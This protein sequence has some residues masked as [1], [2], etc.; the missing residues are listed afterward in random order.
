MGVVQIYHTHTGRLRDFSEVEK[1]RRGC[2]PQL[3]QLGGMGSAEIY[4]IEPFGHKS[5]ELFVY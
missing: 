5:C 1:A 2:G 3:M 4:P